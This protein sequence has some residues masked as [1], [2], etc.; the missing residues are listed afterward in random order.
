MLNSLVKKQGRNID[1]ESDL[2]NFDDR[3]PAHLKGKAI[4]TLLTGV[5]L[6]GFNELDVHI[7]MPKVLL[8]SEVRFPASTCLKR[9]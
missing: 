8:H 7:C 3:P 4:G 2:M 1:D 9:R 6:P 5:V